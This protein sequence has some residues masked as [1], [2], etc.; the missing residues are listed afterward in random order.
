MMDKLLLPNDY[1]QIFQKHPQSKNFLIK[2]IEFPWKAN[3]N[4]RS[5]GS[6][7]KKDRKDST[8][9]LIRNRGFCQLWTDNKWKGIICIIGQ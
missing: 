2:F 9:M 5:G 7:A 3:S 4:I 8:A 6:K 1:D